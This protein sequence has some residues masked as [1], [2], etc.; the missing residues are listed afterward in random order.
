MLPL[1]IL[2]L[3]PVSLSLPRLFLPSQYKCEDGQLIQTRENEATSIFW[4][5]LNLGQRCI[6]IF[7]PLDG[8]YKCCYGRKGDCDYYIQK[9]KEDELPIWYYT[10][11]CPDFLFDFDV[12]E[13]TCHLNFTS[14]THE[15]YHEAFDAD[16]RMLGKCRT[17]GKTTLKF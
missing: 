10:E 8:L 17:L 3:I 16:L 14:Q 15:G 1:S 4:D 7:K 9:H 13:G 12:R 6:S 5:G 2:I 11:Q